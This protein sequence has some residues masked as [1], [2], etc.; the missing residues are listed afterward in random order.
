MIVSVSV[1]FILFVTAA[2]ILWSQGNWDNFRSSMITVWVTSAIVAIFTC[3]LLALVV[4]HV[5]LIA[6][7]KTTYRFFM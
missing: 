4:F 1:N 5:Y 2:A 3:L 7:A 6:T